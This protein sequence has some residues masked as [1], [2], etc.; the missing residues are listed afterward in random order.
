MQNNGATLALAILNL[1]PF[2]A[3]PPLCAEGDYDVTIPESTP[4]GLYVIRVGV[5]GDDSIYGCSEPFE[6]V[7]PGEDLWN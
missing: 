1:I 5:F 7:A 6:V 2:P 4:V 3:A